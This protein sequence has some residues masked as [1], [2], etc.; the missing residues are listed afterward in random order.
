[1]SGG[2][3][4]HRPASGPKPPAPTVRRSRRGR[5]PRC[6]PPARH[7]ASRWRTSRKNIPGAQKTAA[8][9]RGRTHTPQTGREDENMQSFC[10]SH[11][12]LPPHSHRGRVFLYSTPSVRR[13]QFDPLRKMLPFCAESELLQFLN[14]SGRITTEFCKTPP[15]RR[16]SIAMVKNGPNRRRQLI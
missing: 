15:E 9:R 3:T 7:R 8:G 14:N 5:R 11:P 12:P 10:A 6:S 4:G 13:L 2:Q 16:T 1:M